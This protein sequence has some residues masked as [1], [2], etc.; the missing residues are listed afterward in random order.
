MYSYERLFDSLEEGR[1]YRRDT[2]LSFS[3]TIDRDLTKLVEKDKIEKLS[4][5]LYYKPNFSKFGK[6]PPKDT[7]LVYS[8]LDDN[9]FLVYS[10]NQYNGLGLGLTQLYNKLIVYN[11]KRHGIFTLGN[12]IFDFRRPNNGFPSELTSDFLVVDLLNNL[13]ELAEDTDY[14]K[15]QIKANTHRFN[16]EELQ[17]N[18]SYYG[19]IFT[20]RFIKEILND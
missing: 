10:W 20:K 4:G 16:K 9:R 6:L 18:A 8:F 2:L 13:G 14:V 1:T 5:G 12:K 15:R 19:K 11:L 17:Y 3:K 7:E